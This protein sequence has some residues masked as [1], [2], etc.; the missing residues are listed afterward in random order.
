[1]ESVRESVMAINHKEVSKGDVCWFTSRFGKIV[2]AD[3]ISLIEENGVHAVNLQ[4]HS[5]W[6]FTTVLCEKCFWTEKKAKEA[7]RKSRQKK[8]KV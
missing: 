1:M 5:D 7:K 4:D 6:C 3:V 8:D 2:S